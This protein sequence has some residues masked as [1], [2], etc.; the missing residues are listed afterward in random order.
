M[1]RI[2]TLGDTLRGSEGPE[3]QC[4]TNVPVAKPPAVF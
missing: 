1:S 4:G 2:T 3:D